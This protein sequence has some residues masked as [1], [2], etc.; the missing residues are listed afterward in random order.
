MSSTPERHSGPV[1]PSAKK[2]NTSAAALRI[3]TVFVALGM[4]DP[5]ATVDGARRYS[6]KLN[7]SCDGVAPS[8]RGAFA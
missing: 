8:G 2:A 6:A 3:S 7:A 1:V 5:L 4:R